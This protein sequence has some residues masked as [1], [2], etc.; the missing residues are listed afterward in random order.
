MNPCII[1]PGV[2]MTL[3]E[4]R[5]LLKKGRGRGR[6]SAELATK[7]R[8]AK[9]LVA[10]NRA[11]LSPKRVSLKRRKNPIA[12][13]PKKRGRPK[14]STKLKPPKVSRGR[15]RPLGSKDTKKRKTKVT[16][17]AR[18]KN[19]HADFPLME[20]FVAGVS[21]LTKHMTKLSDKDLR[22]EARMTVKQAKEITAAGKGRGRPSALTRAK[23][24]VA[25]EITQRSA[26]ARGK[27]TPKR[28]LGRKRTG[29]GAVSARLVDKFRLKRKRKRSRLRGNRK[30][31]RATKALPKKN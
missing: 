24:L 28:S 13:P 5:E 16:D 29:R 30:R 1:Y 9:K 31:T 14:G 23:K 10:E 15:G 2:T 18:K 17:K 8:E 7:L 4:A 11:P 21:K 12:E 26:K 19:K 20:F 3:Q 25:E 6:P 22:K 27:S